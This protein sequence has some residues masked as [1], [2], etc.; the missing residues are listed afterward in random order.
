MTEQTQQ[1]RTGMGRVAFKARLQDIQKDVDAGYPLTI[2]YEKHKDGLGI[3]YSQFARYAQRYIQREQVVVQD[4]PVKEVEDTVPMSKAHQTMSAQER[5]AAF[6]SN[7][8][9]KPDPIPDKSKLI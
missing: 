6:A 1:K 2:I 3:T 4:K 7:A 5:R 9:F 8:F